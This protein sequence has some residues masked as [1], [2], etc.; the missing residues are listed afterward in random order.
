MDGWRDRF[1]DGERKLIR[2][3]EKREKMRS[4]KIETLIERV[5]TIKRST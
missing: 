1:R 3:T 2:C 4:A 5:D